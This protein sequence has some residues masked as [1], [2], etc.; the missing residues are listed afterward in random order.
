MAADPRTSYT[1]WMAGLNIPWLTGRDIGQKYAEVFGT[2]MD[3]QAELERQAIKQRMPLLCAEDALQFIGE[4]RG[5]V[6][7]GEDSSTD[8]YRLRLQNAW[9]YWNV[10]GSAYSILHE[11][12]YQGYTTLALV[13]QN[14]L[15]FTLSTGLAY[16]IDKGGSGGILSLVNYTVLLQTPDGYDLAGTNTVQ[17]AFGDFNLDSRWAEINWPNIAAQRTDGYNTYYVFRH[18]PAEGALQLLGTTNLTFFKDSGSGTTTAIPA[19]NLPPSVDVIDSIIV[20]NAGPNPTIYGSPPWFDFSD[21]Y[22]LTCRFALINYEE[23]IFWSS[24]SINY[25][26]PYPGPWVWIPDD[27]INNTPNA[28]D[29]NTLYSIVNRWKPAKSI[30]MGLFVA[31]G[32]T[33]T[34]DPLGSTIDY[35]LDTIENR[36]SRNGGTIGTFVDGSTSL[37]SVVVKF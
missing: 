34:Y 36:S 6:L 25:T 21:N 27:D 29:I 23:P 8:T 2:V 11:L 37:A 24:A 33:G 14:G 5:N 32:H 1:A 7:G 31:L 35:P 3:N 30:F 10:G 12:Y 26:T 18:G 19:Y 9:Y 13:Q 28:G 4:E 20:E 22:P 17:I 15:V 16:I